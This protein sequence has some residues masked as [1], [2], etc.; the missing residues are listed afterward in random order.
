VQVPVAD[1]IQLKAECSQDRA[2]MS[3]SRERDLSRL[4]VAY[5]SAGLVFMVVPGT[6]IGFWNLMSISNAHSADAAQTA[7]AQA[8]GHAQVF[9]WIGSFILGIGFYSILKLR[10][11]PRFPIS[12]GW[13]CWLFW[14]SG[15][16]TCWSIGF[17]QWNWRILLPVSAL[18]EIC[19][20][21]LF[22]S[23]M[24]DYHSSDRRRFPEP[25]VSSPS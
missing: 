13:A 18:L 21:L 5:V 24:S 14:I 7:W 20:F 6:L 2:F 23:S 10:R 9:G 3:A 12:T 25:W 16:L 22:F 1:L 17:W 4:L 11:L 19:A 15:V 8:H